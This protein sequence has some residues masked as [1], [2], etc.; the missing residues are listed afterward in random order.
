VLKEC[1]LTPTEVDCFECHGTGTSLGDP[2]EVGSFR[3]VMSVTPRNEPLVIT[4]SKSNVAHSEG[5]AGFCGFFKCLLQVAHCEGA[6]NVH[7]RVKNP[8]L[9]ME[10]FPCQMLSEGVTMRDDAAYSG[11]S[12]FGFGGTNAH[13]EAWG[14]NI[15]TSRGEVTGDPAHRFLKKLSMA[16]PAEIT[17]NGDDVDDWDTTGLDPRADPSTQWRVFLDEDGVVVWEKDDDGQDYGD[18]FF[19]QGSVN[20]WR[21]EPLD[22]DGNISGL[23]YGTITLEG[24]GQDSFQIVADNDQNKVYHPVVPYCSQKSTPIAFGKADRDLCWTIR[25]QEGESFRIEFHQQDKE[26]SIMWYRTS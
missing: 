19:L 2:I 20:N 23:W 14:K 21:A 15:F 9:D 4:S 13:A 25:G 7:L 18:E 22:R 26:R 8:H 3:K 24:S 16:P 12:S 1:A 11:V 10:G 6:A 17:M 5:G